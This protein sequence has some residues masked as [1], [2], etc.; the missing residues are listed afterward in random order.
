M[1]TI[2]LN[3]FMLNEDDERMMD[4]M[5]KKCSGDNDIKPSINLDLMDEATLEENITAYGDY[6][7][8]DGRETI[9]S[10]DDIGMD[11]Y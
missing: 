9:D 6:N 5:N 11:I 10:L 2:D 1:K 8:Y 4:N 3:Q 7:D